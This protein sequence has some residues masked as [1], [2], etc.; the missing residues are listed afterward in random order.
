M[1]GFLKKLLGDRRGNVLAITAACM[2]LVIGAAGL[3]VDTIQWT[4]W[5]RQLQRAADSAALAGVY[6]RVGATTVG[7]TTNTPKAVCKDLGLN[8][9]T[10]MG[11]KSS[12][13]PCSSINTV[14]SYSSINY[15]GN[16]TVSNA[17][18]MS[19]R[20]CVTVQVQQALPFSGYFS[21]FG[22]SA[23]VITASATAASVPGSA[24]YCVLCLD[25][26]ASDTGITI[27]G[28]A[29][30]NLGTCSLM[31][32]SANQ[33]GAAT[34][35][36]SGGGGAGSTVVAASID[37]VGSVHYSSQW[38]VGSYN[39]SSSYIADPFSG[40]QS[41]IPT[42]SSGCNKTG[43][44]NATNGAHG[45]GGNVDYSSTHTASDVVCL[46][47][48]QTI[49]G[50]VTLGPATYVINAG[51]LSMNNGSLSCTGCTIILTNFSNPAN[52]GSVKLTGGSLSLS[53]PT[54]ATATASAVGNQ[55]WK[56]ISIYQDPRATDDG[57][58]TSYENKING[59]TAT[60]VQGVVYF[61]NQSLQFVGGGNNIAACLQ[62]VA[63]RVSFSGNSLIKAASQC[64]DYG[65]G[66][67]GGGRRVRLVA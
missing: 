31:A 28:S 1:I 50:N 44:L 11:L 53:P 43:D 19:Y 32:D 42:S 49:S 39:P 36:N 63:K 17:S 4:L 55:T 29:N 48:N 34:N 16:C 20:V 6:D 66:S 51:D 37:A 35:G 65:M 12:S 59:N 21:S 60:S 26:S 61:G 58:Q 23:P 62:I 40:L 8:L 30:L 67:I 3:S 9:H 38:S 14:G 57:K 15:D 2:P 56:G 13:T 52:T 18:N 27:S 33:N 64:G 25:P 10:W 45:N 41:N 47:G 22:F 46:S 24:E 5:K 54:P 7:D